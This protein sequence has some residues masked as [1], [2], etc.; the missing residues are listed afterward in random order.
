VWITRPHKGQRVEDTIEWAVA[1]LAS[2]GYS[3]TPPSVCS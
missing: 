3:V 2:H 1:Y